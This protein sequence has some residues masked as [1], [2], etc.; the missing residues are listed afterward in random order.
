MLLIK[1]TKTVLVFDLISLIVQILHGSWNRW[2]WQCKSN[3]DISKET[4]QAER[5]VGADVLKTLPFFY[6]LWVGIIQ[7]DNQSSL[8]SISNNLN[9]RIDNI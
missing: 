9:P 4:T 8:Y 3:P 6:I 2:C 7:Q 1:Y 5:I